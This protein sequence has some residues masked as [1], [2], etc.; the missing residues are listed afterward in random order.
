VSAL[1]QPGAGSHP[2]GAL[3]FTRIED[4]IAGA[5]V[6]MMLRIQKERMAQAASLDDAAYFRE[7]G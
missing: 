5:D 6:V 7:F 2:E 1:Q 3:R 4:G